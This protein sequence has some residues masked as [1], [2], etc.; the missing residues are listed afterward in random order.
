M[1]KK[2]LNAIFRCNVTATDGFKYR[3]KYCESSISSDSS[4]CVLY[5][6][7]VNATIENPDKADEFCRTNNIT[8]N[9]ER[10]KSID[11]GE[12]NK[13]SLC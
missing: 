13:R 7:C 3:G 9:T 6:G 12:L 5:D 8:Y 2:L 10:V 1:F 11:K 4:L